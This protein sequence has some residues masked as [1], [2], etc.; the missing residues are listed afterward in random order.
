M[1]PE[2]LFKLRGMHINMNRMK[3]CFSKVHSNYKKIEKIN[4]KPESADFHYCFYT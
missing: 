3:K 1:I 2:N 4:G